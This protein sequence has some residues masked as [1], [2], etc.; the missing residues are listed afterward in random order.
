MEAIVVAACARSGTRLSPDIRWAMKEYAE[1][2]NAALLALVE[3][4]RPVIVKA[5]KL[6]SKEGFEDAA[7]DG[8]ALLT[9]IDAALKG[10]K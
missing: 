5:I 1:A 6:V 7:K 9:K 2:E 10:K 8:E 4:C 3:R